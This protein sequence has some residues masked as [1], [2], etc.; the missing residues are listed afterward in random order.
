M[1]SPAPDTG[2]PVSPSLT[3]TLEAAHMRPHSGPNKTRLLLL[4][5]L[6]VLVGAIISGL[7][8]LLVLLIHAVTNLAFF[9]ELSLANRSPAD[10]T[11][12]LWVLA[13]PAAGGLLVGLMALYGARGIRGTVFRRPWS[14]CSPTKAGFGPLSRS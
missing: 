9:G 5:L 14:R 12:G 7:G 2:I 13:V 11:L 4:S 10:N 1:N 6:A 3:P 8:K